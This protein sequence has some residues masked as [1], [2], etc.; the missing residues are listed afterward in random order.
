MATILMSPF[1]Q[2]GEVPN[3]T[4][5]SGRIILREDLLSHPMM[6]AAF[7][8][9]SAFG[10]ALLLAQ[11]AAAQPVQSAQNDKLE[12]ITVTSQKRATNIQATPAAID[13]YTGTT[14]AK[15]KILTS[16]DLAHS[17]VG[18]S[19]TQNSPQ[20]LELNIRGV[21]NTR[22]TS[23]TADQSVSTFVDEV[24]VS[25]SGN[26]NSNFYDIARIEVLRGP[27]GVLLGK[28]VAGGAINVISNVP[29]YERSGKI[30][31]GIGNYDL[32][33]ATGYLTGAL[34]DEWAGRVAFQYVNHGGYAKD[35]LHNV[36]LENLDSQQFRGQLRYDPKSSDFRA[37]V[38]IDY[39]KETSNG[40]NRVA[41]GETTCTTAAQCFR[42]WSRARDQIAALRGGLSIRE[43]YPVWPTFSGDATPTAQRVLHENF[44]G[45][46][47]M[48]KDVFS[49]VTLTSI[50]G[51]REGRA[52]TLYDQSGLGP[53]NPYNVAFP[54]LFAEP[55]NFIESL[56]Q[57]SQEV[58]L[59]SKYPNSRFDW[60]AG[61]YYQHVNVHQFNRFWGESVGL[62]TLSGE[63]HWDDYGHNEDKAVFAQVGYKILDSLKL[64]VGARYTQDEK[65]G[66]QKG[67]AVA[68]GD[69]FAPADKSPLTPL[70]VVPG[71]FTP[72]SA[73]WSKLTPQATLSFKP[74]EDLMTYA[75]ISVGFK[76]GGFQNDASNAFAA[77]AP[78]RPESVT[79]YEVG[80]K[81]D[82]LDHSARWNTSLFWMEYTDL[83]VQRTDGTCLCNVI[84]NAGGATIKGIESE[85]QYSPTHWLQA[86][87]SGSVLDAKYTD[88]ID[89]VTKISYNGKFLQRT[90]R[91]Q[92][93]VGAEASTSIMGMAD[94]LRLRVN[95][96]HQGEMKW[97][98]DNVQV[99]KAY[100]LLDGRLTFAPPNK[101][102]QVSVW[103]K[104][105]NDKVYRTN[106]IDIFGDAVSSFGAPRTVGVEFTTTF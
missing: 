6:K 61:L 84:A 19:F 12:T 67:T 37:A 48:E 88:Y 98:P 68:T 7:V 33:Q 42:T 64:D 76:G 49:D 44:S 104:N 52:F 14:L 82:F 97:A 46:L 105:L 11:P 43:S 30:T 83:Q 70:A 25:R 24:Y 60:I 18:L 87:L 1:C 73:K 13:A 45:I 47:K 79:N 65:G 34:T 66:T 58:R 103:A 57:V 77:A 53:T 9:A 3:R 20:A 78:Y 31:V 23:P 16:E 55:V 17:A 100:G 96:K 35:L 2:E 40:P 56:D 59:T 89:P 10:S 4:N 38:T 41:F 29:E 99:E 15:N 86:W 63:S 106:I 90:P 69:K 71:F 27:Q 36:E 26:L 74:N 91:Y 72:Y 62:P 8:A 5:K 39:A 21:V 94:A 75:T 51:Y 54:L 22:L 93:A 102:Y 50:T 92:V 95:Y 80:Y 85:M 28:N 81:W 32:H 101:P